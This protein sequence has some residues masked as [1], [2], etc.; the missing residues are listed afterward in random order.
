[1][2]LKECWDLLS[3]VVFFSVFSKVSGFSLVGKFPFVLHSHSTKYS[4]ILLYIDCLPRTTSPFLRYYPNNLLLHRKLLNSPRSSPSLYRILSSLSLPLHL[5]HVYL[6]SSPPCNTPA[7]LTYLT[8]NF[9]AA[10]SSD[11]KRHS[12]RG[13]GKHITTNGWDMLAM[14]AHTRSYS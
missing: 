1:M 3:V 6:C 4:H 2:D 11:P 12:E 7:H 10:K 14:R 5:V 8:A 13:W 9:S